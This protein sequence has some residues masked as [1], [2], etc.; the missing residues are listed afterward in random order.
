M[1]Y[2]C[3]GVLSSP[4]FA[5]HF[6]VAVLGRLSILNM[7]QGDDFEFLEKIHG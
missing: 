7:E 3:G 6:S 1:Y 4:A 2:L 5:I